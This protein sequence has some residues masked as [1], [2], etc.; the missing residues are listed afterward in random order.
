[1]RRFEE[2]AQV[3]TVTIHPPIDLRRKF[4]EKSHLPC[5]WYFDDL[6]TVVISTYFNLRKHW[7]WATVVAFLWAFVTYL[8]CILHETQINDWKTTSGWRLKY[9]FYGSEKQVLSSPGNPRFFDSEFVATFTTS[10]SLSECCWSSSSGESSAS[11]QLRTW[12]DNSWWFFTNPIEKYADRQIG[13]SPHKSGVQIPKIF[14]LP[15]S[16]SFLS[17]P[18]PW[19]KPSYF[20]LYWMV[21]QRKFRWETSDIRTRSEESEIRFVWEEIRKR[22]DSFEKRFVRD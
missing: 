5:S 10:T 19:K 2:K 11:S 1:M 9:P 20:P 21:N 7:P 3:S 13:P 22:L 16:N 15:P 18:E 17:K 4:T 14:E 12:I 6:K 8:K